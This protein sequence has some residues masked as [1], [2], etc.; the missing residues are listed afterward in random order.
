[1]FAAG[2]FA[3][4][5][6]AA[7]A[8]GAAVPAACCLLPRWRCGD[9]PWLAEK[10]AA[11]ALWFLRTAWTAGCLRIPLHFSASS[12]P[13]H[14]FPSPFGHLR[15]CLSC[16]S[17]SFPCSTAFCLPLECLCRRFPDLLYALKGHPAASLSPA[18]F[19]RLAAP[20]PVR[21]AN[22]HD[23]GNAFLNFRN[24]LPS[25]RL[26]RLT[27]GTRAALGARWRACL[28]GTPAATAY[29]AAPV[30]DFAVCLPLQT[31][32]DGTTRNL[33]LP[34]RG[35]GQSEQAGP[36]KAVGVTW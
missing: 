27:G 3:P 34:A 11:R 9:E 13:L 22:G 31:M 7:S 8:A 36:N 33:L 28:P 18:A 24:L 2:L 30:A 12:L 19:S 26:H 23:D 35:W 15:C 25:T 14:P 32:R 29:R 17:P 10:A 4:A 6:A 21:C 20:P 5:G 16:L 1:L